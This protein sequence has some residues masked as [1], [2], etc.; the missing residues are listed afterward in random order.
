VDSVQ[1]L[2][3]R[4]EVPAGA[5]NR[6]VNVMAMVAGMGVLLAGFAFFRDRQQFSFSWLVAFMFVTT[7]SLGS[8]W[9]VLIHHL[10]R[11]GWGVVVRRIPETVTTLFPVLAVLFIPV[12]L[13][14]KDLY[15]WAHPQAMS[16]GSLLGHKQPYLNVPF[17]IVRAAVCF[18]LWTVIGRYFYNASVRQDASGDVSVTVRLQ[19]IAAPSMVVLALTLSLGAFDWLMSLDPEW[20]S[21]IFGVYI[22]A[23]STLAAF[24]FLYLVTLRLHGAGYL[25]TAL[26]LDHQ[27][28]L[29]R[30]M[31]AF[32]VFWA[33]IAFSQFFLIWYGNMPEETLFYAHRMEGSWKYVTLIIACCHFPVP[34]VV[35]MSRWTKMRPPVMAAMAVWILV[36]H[37]I[38]LYWLAMPV[39]H[40]E[41][42]HVSWMDLLCLAV[43]VVLFLTAFLRQLRTRSLVP[44]GDPRL[45][46]SLA[47]TNDY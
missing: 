23:G 28:D 11:A 44:L 43:V 30:W 45:R 26:R 4:I 38:D 42:V 41:G 18:L 1:T 29:G 7:I 3:D 24:A 15:E 2:N 8:L 6:R 27:R 25:A 13:G 19:R 9:I 20:Y 5:W 34:F 40:H 36:L 22:F 46:E 35:L 17:F 37:Y 14:M 47:L 33:Y 39:L 12:I 32:T 16:H 10:T 21:T 31:F